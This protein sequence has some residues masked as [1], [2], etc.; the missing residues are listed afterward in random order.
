MIGPE[1]AVAV[2]GTHAGAPVVDA[3]LVQ[4]RGRLRSARAVSPPQRCPK[5]RRAA[6]TRAR[7]RQLPA[8]GA[9]HLA[10][11]AQRAAQA[12]LALGRRKRT[13]EAPRQARRGAQRAGA[14]E[15]AGQRARRANQLGDAG[16][17]ACYLFFRLWCP[18]GVQRA[19]ACAVLAGRS[20]ARD[21]RAWRR[22]ACALAPGPRSMSA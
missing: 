16:Q 19:A 14:R 21:A 5:N 12:P 10:H 17:H 20:A 4:Q 18:L 1:Q 3:Q 6:S 2:T 13:R 7:L 8:D 22:L 11:A 15:R 9:Q